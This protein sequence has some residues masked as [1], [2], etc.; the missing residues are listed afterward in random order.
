MNI[1]QWLRQAAEQLQNSGSDSARLDAELLLCYLIDK[2]RSYLIA[3]SEQLLEGELLQ[4]ANELLRR[5]ESGEPVAYILGNREFWSLELEVS[6][7]V[8]IPRPD[9]EA[10]VEYILDLPLP[11]HVAFA[12]LGTG[13]GAIAIALAAERPDWHGVAVDY[14]K[15]AALIA[16]S[17]AAK[18]QC[19]NLQVTLGDWLTG[20]ADS[21]LDLVVSNP[22]YIDASDSHL[23]QGD[24]RF[25]PITALVAEGNG[26]AD[27]SKIADQ[28]TRVLREGGYLV[29]EHGYNQKEAVSEL[30]VKAGYRDIQAHRDVGGNWRFH[31]AVHVDVNS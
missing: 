14:S 5:R 3:F 27:I 31:S 28:A 24:V 29:V 4:K 20:F 30:L 21:S 15:R 19:S 13:S 17:N 1:Q 10:L 22:P 18:Y 16:A 6:E 9:T 8:L 11:E 12:D 26:L 25:E 23:K 2:P 7:D